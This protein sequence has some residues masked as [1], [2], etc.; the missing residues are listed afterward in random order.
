MI[1]AVAFVV[2]IVVLIVHLNKPHKEEQEFN[3]KSVYI[4]IMENPSIT[5]FRK[6][7]RIRTEQPNPDY[8]A[9]TKFLLAEAQEIGLESR[10][11]EC[12]PS[13]PIVVLSWRG[14]NPALKSIM[15]NCHTDVVPVFNNM[16]IIKLLAVTLLSH[17][18]MSN[19]D[20]KTVLLGKFHTWL[21]SQDYARL[22]AKNQSLFQ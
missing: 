11:I 13:K 12:V 14:S 19:Q 15:L 7:L 3:L 6:F 9:C 16:P 21:W 18:R 4:N 10:V 1:F 2:A 20:F 17:I 5:R 8:A 22:L